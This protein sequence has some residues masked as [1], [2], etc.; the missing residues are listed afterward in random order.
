MV[1]NAGPRRRDRAGGAQGR[2]A[3]GDERPLPVCSENQATSREDR[4]F[5]PDTVFAHSQ[6]AQQ[7]PASPKKKESLC[8][9]HVSAA[10]KNRSAALRERIESRHGTHPLDHAERLGLGSQDYA[11]TGIDA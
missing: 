9:D 2:T 3:T 8:V 5:E 1:E 6:N 11:L 7:R 4:I 10:D